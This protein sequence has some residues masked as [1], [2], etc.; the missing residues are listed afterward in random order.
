MPAIRAPFL[1]AEACDLCL[2]GFLGVVCFLHSVNSR[3]HSQKK[4]DSV[5]SLG[6]WWQQ[7][8]RKEKELQAERGITGSSAP[9]PNNNRNEPT[10]E[11]TAPG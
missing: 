7:H 3:M 8:S 2:E 6:T 11:A 10:E 5:L 4:G 9:V 1:L